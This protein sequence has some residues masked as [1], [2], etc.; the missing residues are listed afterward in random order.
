MDFDFT[1]ESITPNSS[2][3]LTL[4]SVGAFDLP[5]GTTAQRPGSVSAGGIRW[6]TSLII[7]AI[8]F[9]NGTAWIPIS[10]STTGYITVGAAAT[11]Q[12]TATPLTYTYN[13]VNAT[14]GG[15]AVLMPTP[16]YV[17]QVCCIE[18][19]TGGPLYYYPQVGGQIENIGT[20]NAYGNATNGNTCFVATSTTQ[21]YAFVSSYSQGVGISITA[22][23]SQ[24]NQ[25][26]FANAGVLSFNG[27]TTGL[28]PSTLTTGDITLGGTLAIANGGTGQTTAAAAFNAINPMTTTGDMI[29]ANGTNTAT[30]LAGNTSSTV[31]YLTQTGNGTI[32]AAPIWTSIPPQNIIV[33]TSSPL[34]AGV[35]VNTRY[36]YLVSGTTTITMPTAIGNTNMYTVKNVGSNIVTIAT[37]SSQTIDGSTSVPIKVKYT[38]LTLVSD[39]ANWNLI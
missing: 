21:W 10:S 26:I 39:G 17:G 33:N 27:G 6:N 9:Y 1:T 32:S 35:T 7:P 20:N 5:S 3:I 28:T 4:N 2:T 31:Q 16:S 8:E 29:Y 38:S 30:R 34:T 11:S 13:V 19:R 36:I 15:T 22:N 25:Y 24:T 18:N 23:P 37:T 12:A 14:S